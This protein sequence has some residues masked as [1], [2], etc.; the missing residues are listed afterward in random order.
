[1]AEKLKI[2]EQATIRSNLYDIAL[3]AIAREGLETEIV[4]KG[5]L[6]HLENDQF[7]RVT[8]TYCNPEKFDLEKERQEYVDKTAAAAERK[9]KAAEKAA[10][11]AKK[12]AEKVN[13]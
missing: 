7:A 9:A 13:S 12:A 4:S 5:A 1:M 10:E 3:S 8:I 6:I 2:A 11:K